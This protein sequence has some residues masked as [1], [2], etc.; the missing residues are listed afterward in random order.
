[1]GLVLPHIAKA[2]DLGRPALYLASVHRSLIA[3]MD[4]LRIGVCILD[5]RGNVVVAN[6]EFQRQR[7]RYGAFRIDPGG[8]LHLHDKADGARFK[9]LF[10][11]ALEHGRYG[12]RPRKEAI[13]TAHDD[14]IGALCI[15][16]APLDQVE[17]IG[18]RRL[19]GAI[20]YSLDTSLPTFCDPSL[21]QSVFALTN[22]EAELIELV[23]D[24][25]TN[26]EI[27]DRRSRS[28]ETVNTQVKSVLSKTQCANRTQFVRLFMNFGADYLRPRKQRPGADSP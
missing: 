25:L 27:A 18:S 28:V 13:A 4:R 14:G 2:L 15:E 17:E 22:A 26:A 5:R 1:M 11:D 12:A 16:I 24:G 9:E 23:G 10:S 8:R 20:V 19:C 7:E 21:L 6:E 3:A